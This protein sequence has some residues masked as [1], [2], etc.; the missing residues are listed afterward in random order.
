ML[1]VWKPTAELGRFLSQAASVR[2]ASPQGWCSL[3][4]EGWVFPCVPGSH[5][6][7]EEHQ[8]WANHALYSSPSTRGAICF[9]GYRVSKQGWE[10]PGL[11]LGKPPLHRNQKW[12]QHN[13]P[14]KDKE[15][16]FYWSVLPKFHVLLLECIEDFH[17]FSNNCSVSQVF[18]LCAKCWGHNSEGK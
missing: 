15:S 13:T 10:S 16:L 18:R 3:R 11:C 12:G 14:Q 8:C 9:L 4:K 7:E 1:L 17:S 5:F 2:E 6:K